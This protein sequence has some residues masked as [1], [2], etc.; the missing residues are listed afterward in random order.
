MARVIPPCALTGTR[1]LSASIVKGPAMF[2]KI[3]MAILEGFAMMNPEYVAY[4]Y[5]ETHAERVPVD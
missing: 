1:S 3:M 4:K 2:R 5:A